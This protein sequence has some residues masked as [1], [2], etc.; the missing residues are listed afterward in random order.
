MWADS[1]CH[2]QYEAIPAEALDRAAD[3]GIG[4]VI[5]V[6]TDAQQ[7]QAAISVAR[8]HPGQVWATVGMHPHDASQGVDG[9]I[10]LL[11]EPEVVGVGECGRCSGGSSPPR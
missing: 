7:S 11:G 10:A 8:A 9:L 4:R 6:G 2:L 3:A 1:H 5:C